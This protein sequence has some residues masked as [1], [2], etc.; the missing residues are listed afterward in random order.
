MSEHVRKTFKQ[1]LDILDQSE[2]LIREVI[3]SELFDAAGVNN[4]KR[5]LSKKATDRVM[6]KI[7]A[8]RSHH[9]KAAFKHL[10]ANLPHV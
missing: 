5:N 7:V 8:I 6:H 3:E 1:A 10:R 9:L 4:V 2:P